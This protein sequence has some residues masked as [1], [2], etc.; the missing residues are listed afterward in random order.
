V[1][2]RLQLPER[3]AEALL[4]GVQSGDPVLK[5]FLEDMPVMRAE[6][7]PSSPRR[8]RTDTSETGLEALIVSDL[9]EQGWIAGDPKDY[10]R[11]YAVDLKQLEA[12]LATTQPQV[13][14]AADLA[15]AGPVRQKFLASVGLYNSWTKR[16]RN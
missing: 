1:R 7:V 14:E 16:G 4:H 12:F 13:A 5:A 6:R 15:N 11:K 8:A 2:I 10:D 9:L 3:T